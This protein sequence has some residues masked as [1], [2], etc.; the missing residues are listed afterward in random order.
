MLRTIQVDFKRLFLNRRYYYCIVGMAFALLVSGISYKKDR[1]GYATLEECFSEATF[2]GFVI[3]FYM[4]CVVGG[5]LDY[6]MDVKNHYMRYM[7]IR[8]GIHSYAVS[9]TF[10]SA[11]SGYISMF[12]G[13]VL[14]CGMMSVYLVFQSGTTENLFSGGTEFE[15]I[16]WNILIFSLLG[17]ALSVLGL[18][19]TAIVPNVFVGMT[20]PVLIYY[21][22]I[23]L[24]NKYWSNPVLMPSCIYFSYNKLFG[25]ERQQFLYAL[26]VT[27]C[28]II[29]LYRGIYRRMKRRGEHV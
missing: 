24:T 19:A 15:S 28:F 4:L 25:G 21:I 6:C 2:G 14:F 29:I 9:K 3:L 10:V 13:Q 20:T 23:T 5:G 18:F 26:L 11:V 12:L 22:V 16:S 8:N 1:Y 17:S 27:I 7:V